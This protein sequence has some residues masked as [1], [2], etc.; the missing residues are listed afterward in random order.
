MWVRAK[1]KVRFEARQP[2]CQI[3]YSAQKT[4]KWTAHYEPEIIPD[5]PWRLQHRYMNV[6]LSEERFR[7]LF[8]E[9]KFEE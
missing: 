3:T 9:M 5:L 7:E 8:E 1:E 6:R 4:S 2:D